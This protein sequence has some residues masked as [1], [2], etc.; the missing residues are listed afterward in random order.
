MRQLLQK[1]AQSGPDEAPAGVGTIVKRH[2]YG[3]GGILTAMNSMNS[4]NL[5]ENDVSQDSK[6]AEV[7]LVQSDSV[8]SSSL[9][10][11]YIAMKVP[12]L[13]IDS[14]QSLHNKPNHAKQQ[15]QTKTMDNRISSNLDQQANRPK[16]TIISQN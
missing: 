14:V 12:V 13:D 5:R 8:E 1:T 3:G 9:K 10:A 7:D 4:T 6:I 2:S 11:S 15:I 16:R